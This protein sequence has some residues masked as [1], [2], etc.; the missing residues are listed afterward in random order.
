[1]SSVLQRDCFIDILMGITK[2]FQSNYYVMTIFY[3]II[4]APF[5]RTSVLILFHKHEVQNIKIIKEKPKK[6]VGN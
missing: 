5:T 3:V 2:I 6:K 4:A 1:M